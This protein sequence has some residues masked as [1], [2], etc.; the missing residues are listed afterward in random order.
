[1]QKISSDFLAWSSARNK[2]IEEE[3]SKVMKYLSQSVTYQ[4]DVSFV[5]KSFV[6]YQFVETK[7]SEIDS[8]HL[9][10]C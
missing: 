2:Q 6:F 10:K 5:N 9:Q 1:M 3:L 8:I 7:I 4:I